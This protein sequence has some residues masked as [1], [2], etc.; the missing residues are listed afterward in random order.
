ML[1]RVC[2]VECVWVCLIECVGWCLGVFSRVC[3][4]VFSRVCLGVLSV[5]SGVWVCLGGVGWCLGVC[6]CKREGN[7][8]QV[9][10]FTCF[11]INTICC[12]IASIIY[13]FREKQNGGL[14]CP[15]IC[16]CTGHIFSA[17]GADDHGVEAA[18]LQPSENTLVLD[19]GHGPVL[20]EVVVVLDAHLV[21]VKVPS[22]MAPVYSQVV[23]TGTVDGRGHLHTGGLWDHGSNK[24]MI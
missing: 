2:S 8:I 13:R 10:L 15:P 23:V 14:T 22:R 24:R 21:K 19:P 20:D 11:R 17:P 16:G 5:L 9:C 7:A 12:Y 3:L 6:V 4:G 18:R 1:S